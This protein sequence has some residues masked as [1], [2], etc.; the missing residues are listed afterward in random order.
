M[1]GRWLFKEEPAHY[2]FSD[3][4][5]DGETD[6][7]GVRNALAQRHLRAMRP[8]DRGFFYHSGGERAVVGL[9]D[10]VSGPRPET[11]DPTRVSVRVRAGRALRRPVPLERLKREAAFRGSTLIR[12][13]RLSVLPLTAEQARR[14]LA[15][16]REAK[17]A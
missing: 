5:R 10:I 9:V 13:P 7:E 15:I 17:P 14:V 2:A 1:A 3:L 8:G 11:E 4:I 16:E 12:I 6:W